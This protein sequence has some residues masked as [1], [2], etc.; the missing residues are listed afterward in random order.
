[1]WSIIS[2]AGIRSWR[3][4]RCSI[5]CAI[6]CA[7]CGGSF[8]GIGGHHGVGCFFSYLWRGA[9]SFS[10][11][12]VDVLV[13]VSNGV[14]DLLVREAMS[15]RFWWRGWRGLVSTPWAGVDVVDASGFLSCVVDETRIDVD[16]AV[17]VFDDAVLLFL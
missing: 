5:G 3:D 16:D 17:L 1:V 7:S 9:L 11:G 6:G 10:N 14:V 15:C 2:V 8:C 4:C 13:R 12:V